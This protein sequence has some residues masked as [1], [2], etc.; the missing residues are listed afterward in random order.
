MAVVFTP[1]TPITAAAAERSIC[2]TKR[3]TAPRNQLSVMP[4]RCYAAVRELNQGGHAANVRTECR[5][6]AV[7]FRLSVCI[8]SL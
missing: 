3:G 5:D 8:L 7:V 2:H 1:R 4:T 6:A